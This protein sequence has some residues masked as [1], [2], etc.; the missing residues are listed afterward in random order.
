M[1]LYLRMVPVE[2]WMASVGIRLLPPIREMCLKDVGL[3]QQ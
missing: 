1:T 3:V 2:M